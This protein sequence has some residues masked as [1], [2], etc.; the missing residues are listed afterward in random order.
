MSGPDL[1]PAAE[2]GERLVLVVGGVFELPG[3][4]LV[5]TG[6][7][8]FG[9]WPQPL[10]LVGRTVLVRMDQRPAA[11]T[12]ARGLEHFD[13]TADGHFRPLGRVGMALGGIAR[14]DVAEGARVL[15]PRPAA[16]EDRE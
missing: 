13:S 12:R 2:P 9:E 7:V 10:Q 5:V 3:R 14:S 1:E 8:D 11:H 6:Q 4:G 16:I 15:A